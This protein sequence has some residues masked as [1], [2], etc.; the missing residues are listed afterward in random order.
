M[1]E[2]PNYNKNDI[3]RQLRDGDH[4]LN[5]F[6]NFISDLISIDSL[7]EQKERGVLALVLDKGT[8][9]LSTKQLFVLQGIINKFGYECPRCE[10]E[11]D[12]NEI[13]IYDVNS[14]CHSCQ[15]DFERMK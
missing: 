12:W 11:L 8:E 1:K 6:H 7:D 13:D 4:H 15:H 2:I 14:H 5:M 10:E 9:V 3:E